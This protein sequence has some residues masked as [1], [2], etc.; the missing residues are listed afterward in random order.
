MTRAKNHQIDPSNNAIRQSSITPQPL[1]YKQVSDY[2]LTVVH[3]RDE[4]PLAMEDISA[5]N[6]QQQPLPRIPLAHQLFTG[7][8]F[9]H[10]DEPL[11]PLFFHSPLQRQSSS[12]T[13]RGL[14][15]ESSSHSSSH[16][17][18]STTTRTIH[19]EPS[20]NRPSSTSTTRTT[21]IEPPSHRPALTKKQRRNRKRRAKR[22]NFEVIRHLYEDIHYHWQ[23]NPHRYEHP[24]G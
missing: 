22:Y 8:L 1:E 14:P 12:P 21:P 4:L 7:E 15:I 18:S 13:T 23:T 11:T 9:I 20:S 2:E 24:L 5:D 10:A 19:I 16:H 17:T 6:E 3:V